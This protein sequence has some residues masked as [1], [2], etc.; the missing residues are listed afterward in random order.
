[1]RI[2]GIVF[3]KDGTLFD[4][5]SSWG[6]A[7]FDFL[8]S[9]SDGDSSTLNSL[10][11]ALEFDL[12][13]K[14]FFSESIF[15]AGT[16]QETMDRLQPIIPKKTEADIL[17]A[18]Q[19]HYSNLEQ[20]PVKNLH[21]ILKRLYQLGYLMSIATNDLEAS[22]ISQLKKSGI[23]EFFTEIIGADSGY[24]AKPEPFQLLAISEKIGLEPLE[25]VMVG[26][27]THDM[28]AARRANFRACAVLTGV[29]TELDLQ[30]YSDAVFDDISYLLSW[31]EDQNA[32]S[33]TTK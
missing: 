19:F 12:Q 5:Q 32:I 4:F 31:I 14:I 2:K 6:A 26:D 18:Q 3:D 23:S 13:R 25:I 10:G 22:A 17:T 8:V 20:K 24:G 28:I 33:P 27:S 15:I 1:M 16:A 9:L 21:K 7:T 29:A 11:E 30:A